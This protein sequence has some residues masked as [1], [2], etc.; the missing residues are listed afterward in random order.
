MSC[1][2]GMP[3]AA[4]CIDCMDDDG[5]GAPPERATNRAAPFAA[6]FP[7]RCMSC[8]DPISIGEQI[9][10]TANGIGYEHERHEP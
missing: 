2:H 4:S 8:D 10:S 5:L 7:G 3:T 9:R 6:R 1:P